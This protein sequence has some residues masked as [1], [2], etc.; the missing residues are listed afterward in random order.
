L[1]TFTQDWSLKAQVV[2]KYD[3]KHY[4]NARGEGHFLK[5]EL[6][7]ESNCQIEATMFND[8]ANKLVDVFQTGKTYI[9]K[10]G[11]VGISNKKFTTIQNDYN[12]TLDV[13]SHVE[14]CQDL[15][16]NAQI[17]KIYNYKSLR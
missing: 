2:K 5:I 8:A 11:R 7:D 1:N 13:F 15:R 4:K 17:R 9:I 16:D 12:L 10:G 14:E 6:M 3:F